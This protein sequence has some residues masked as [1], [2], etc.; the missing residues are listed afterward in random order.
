MGSQQ[1]AVPDSGHRPYI[2]E[3]PKPGRLKQHHNLKQH[4]SLPSLARQNLSQ[5]R[6]LAHKL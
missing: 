1:F 3:L 6:I 2:D 4:S 5:N